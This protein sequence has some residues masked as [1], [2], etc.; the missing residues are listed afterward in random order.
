MFVRTYQNKHSKIT[1]IEQNY[2]FVN[3]KNSF[4]NEYLHTDEY[5]IVP[6]FSDL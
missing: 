1:R 5:Y 4:S 3:F 6:V 2:S